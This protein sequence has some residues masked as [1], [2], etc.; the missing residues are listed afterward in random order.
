MARDPWRGRR[1]PERTDVG[2]VTAICWTTQEYEEEK[3][4]AEVLHEKDARTY[5]A[6]R[7]GLGMCDNYRKSGSGHVV[8]GKLFSRATV[9]LGG[10]LRVTVQVRW[11]CGCRYDRAYVRQLHYYA[12]GDQLRIAVAE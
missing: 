2:S 3:K 6:R 12:D 9:D 4:L 11:A 1:G 7:A 8:S 10:R 5:H